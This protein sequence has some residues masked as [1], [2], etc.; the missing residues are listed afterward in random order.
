MFIRSLDVRP[1][2]HKAMLGSCGDF[3]CTHLARLQHFIEPFDEQQHPGLHLRVVNGGKVFANGN[4]A[5]S[6]LSNCFVLPI[7]MF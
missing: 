5:C 4:V 6:E 3:S 7:S 2:T 1:F